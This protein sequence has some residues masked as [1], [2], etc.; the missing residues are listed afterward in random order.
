MVGLPDCFHKR[1][2][3]MVTKLSG[4]RKMGQGKMVEQQLPTENEAGWVQSERNGWQKTKICCQAAG[5]IAGA[6][7]STSSNKIQTYILMFFC[8]KVF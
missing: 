1:K 8:L 4:R 2:K 7:C 5:A 3:H 6:S